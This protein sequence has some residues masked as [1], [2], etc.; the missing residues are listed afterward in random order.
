MSTGLRRGALLSC[1]VW[2]ALV[3]LGCARQTAPPSA[4][5]PPPPPPTAEPRAPALATELPTVSPIGLTLTAPTRTGTATAATVSAPTLANRAAPSAAARCA[6]QKGEVR[7][8]EFNSATLARR[9]RYQLYLPPCYNRDP[10]RIFPVLYLLHGAHADDTQWLDLNI[11]S[12]ADALIGQGTIAPLVMV[13]PDGDYRSDEDYGAF[14]ERDLLPQVQQTTRVGTTRAL[15]ALGG[16]SLGG[17]WALQLALTRPGL[18]GAVG[19]H[20]AAVTSATLT[21]LAA[22]SDWQT[23]RVYLDVGRADPLAGGVETF[24]AA[25]RARGLSPEYHLNDGGH[26]RPYWRSQTVQYLQFYAAGW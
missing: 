1:W 15:R 8:V 4:A 17:Y 22:N 7:A 13:M 12:N 16:I 11:T 9:V 19:G 18:F 21:P 23:L 5:V 26:T 3:V 24:A 25:L 14:V 6:E 10:N 2:L 20:S